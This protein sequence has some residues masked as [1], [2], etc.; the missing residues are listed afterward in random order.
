MERKK[1]YAILL[2]PKIGIYSEEGVCSRDKT[3]TY[4]HLSIRMQKCTKNRD[5]KCTTSVGPTDVVSFSVK[6]ELA[7]IC[8][9]AFMDILA[10][11]RQGHSM[12]WIAKKLGIHRNT[13]KKY[14]I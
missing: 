11:H 6:E 4:W 8:T 3:Y 5:E 7:M 2:I 1:I 10:F 13:V 14:I 12:R 9:E